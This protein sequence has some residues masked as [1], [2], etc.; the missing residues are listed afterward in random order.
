MFPDTNVAII[1]A[2]PYGLSIA[3]H[4]RK[5]GIEHKI[6]GHP[7]Q[8][9]AQHMPSGMLL[10]SEGFA[11]SIFDFEGRNTLKR[12]CD[13]RGID[14]A[15]LGLPIRLEDF[16]AYGLECQ[17]AMAPELERCDVARVERSANGFGIELADG[18]FLTSK[19]L[20]VATGVF[21]FKRI[22][23]C[24]SALPPE[25]CSHSADR[26]NLERFREKTVIVI[27]AGASAVDTATLL[28]EQGCRVRL[29]SRTSIEVH[30]K[31]RLPRP[32]YDKLRFPM[33]VIGPG[34]R[35]WLYTAA[36]SVFS[37]MPWEWRSRAAKLPGPAGG[38]PMRE[39]LRRVEQFIGFHICSA[40][41]D[42]SRVA[43]RASSETGVKEVLHADY[44]IAATGFRIDIRQLNFLGRTIMGEI[45]TLEGV[46]LLSSYGESSA[47]GL[48]FAGPITANTFG[49]VVRFVVGTAFAAPRLAHRLAR[50]YRPISVG[51]AGNLR[52]SV[53]RRLKVD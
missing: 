17:H 36:P 3:G 51:K 30:G 43:I 46:P 23:S 45:R 18:R 7:M 32:L 6:F 50:T 2:G 10:K 22:P 24:I 44:V 31:M 40:T 26:L 19:A 11:S 15:D 52:G 42:G 13:D 20:I 16:V 48:F 8:F 47:P 37:W 38:W 39:R 29:I 14:Y 34:W 1:G 27:G 28:N 5:F 35:G 21:H 25:Y 4:L 53:G 41:M 49:P 12:F 33:S 9:W